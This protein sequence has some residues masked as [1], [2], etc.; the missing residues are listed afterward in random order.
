[1][2]IFYVSIIGFII[3][4]VARHR[5]EIKQLLDT[6]R[7]RTR[8]TNSHIT[9]LPSSQLPTT[10]TSVRSSSSATDEKSRSPR[11]QS[12][13]DDVNH[14]RTVTSDANDTK[15]SSPI[16]SMVKP[17]QSSRPQHPGKYSHLLQTI[18]IGSIVLAGFTV[19]YYKGD[20]LLPHRRGKNNTNDELF[21]LSNHSLLLL[22][23]PYRNNLFNERCGTQLVPCVCLH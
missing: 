16:K 9:S 2:F 19:L 22:I 6:V 20:D 17:L 14:R 5:R 12:T 10:V 8:A 3:D 4:L 18:L 13:T 7:D 21:L 1:V 11:K 15:T 23:L